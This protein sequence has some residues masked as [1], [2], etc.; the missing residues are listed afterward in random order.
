MKKKAVFWCVF[1]L[2]ITFF[3]VAVCLSFGSAAVG[4][5]IAAIMIME[6]MN[7][8]KMSGGF[9]AYYKHRGKLD[10]YKKICFVEFL[11]SLCFGV[12]CFILGM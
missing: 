11:I 3:V 5:F 6:A 2:T 1:L 12:I 9:K 4:F 10:K 8:T 7:N